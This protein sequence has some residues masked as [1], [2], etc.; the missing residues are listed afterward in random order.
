MRNQV[1]HHW[2]CIWDLNGKKALIG[3]ILEQRFPGI[4]TSRALKQ[5]WA[6]F[7]KGRKSGQRGLEYNVAGKC[8]EVNSEDGQ[9]SDHERRHV[10]HSAQTQEGTSC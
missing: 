1:R 8:G 5:E 10:K 6:S 9:W 7:A 3:K 4:V 2:H